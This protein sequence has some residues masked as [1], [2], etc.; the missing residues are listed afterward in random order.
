MI[1]RLDNKIGE[2]TSN[3]TI[4]EPRHDEMSYVIR[5]SNLIITLPEYTTII[6]FISEGTNNYIKPAQGDKINCAFGA[7]MM[8]NDRVSIQK[9]DNNWYIISCCGNLGYDYINPQ[10]RQCWKTSIEAKQ[11]QIIKW[12]EAFEVTPQEAPS[13]PIVPIQ[14]PDPDIVISTYMETSPSQ[15]GPQFRVTE[16]R[17]NSYWLKLKERILGN[18]SVE[19][20]YTANSPNGTFVERYIQDDYTISEVKPF[21][22]FLTIKRNVKKTRL[23]GHDPRYG[24][25]RHQVRHR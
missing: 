14:E 20:V 6:N 9:I 19:K 4:M 15:S 5:G 2:I 17:V 12:N 22:R 3:Y 11:N 21:I 8:E 23:G 13:L 25:K 1:S 16:Y 7:L 18:G 24:S 10:Q